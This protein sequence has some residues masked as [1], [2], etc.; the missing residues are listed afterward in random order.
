M[1]WHFLNPILKRS[2][3]VACL[4]GIQFPR[5]DRG[6]FS[7]WCIC[8]I[9]IISDSVSAAL[10]LHALSQ[11]QAVHKTSRSLKQLVQPLALASIQHSLRNL[12]QMFR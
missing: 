6:M 8:K 2:L 3:R 11:A 5:K 1:E 9:C 10:R 7:D 12:L 4:N